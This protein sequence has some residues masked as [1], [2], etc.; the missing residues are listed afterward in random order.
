MPDHLRSAPDARVLLIGAGEIAPSYL[1]ALAHLGVTSI[2][3]LARTQASADRRVASH[4][5]RRGYGGGIET[6]RRIGADYT[7]LIIAT[8]VESLLDVLGCAAAHSRA[9]LMVEKPAALTSADLAN[10]LARHD[11]RRVT[12]ALNRLFF[13]SVS[14]LAAR[15]AV[16]TVTSAEFSFTEWIHRIDTTKYSEAA[17]AR[18]GLSNCIH[19]VGTVF[20]LIGHPAQLTAR[21]D[22]RNVVPWHPAGA[23][24]TGSGYSRRAVPFTFASDWRSAGR[25]SITVRT[26]D[27]SYHLAPMETLQFCRR[28][29]VGLESL[30]AADPGPL[31]CGFVPML[32]AWLEQD[33][34]LEGTTLLGLLET[35][36]ASETIFGYASSA[37]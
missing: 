18:W 13:P 6:L 22:G 32:R 1:D 28:G 9:H 24:F 35:I 30:V 25:W 14:T 15:L 12:V 33:A 11:A 21:Q 34:S 7:H 5:L 4:G 31:K 3:I 2:D 10:W 29:Q 20:H 19:V 16:E 23:V 17:L 36:R 26:T 27:G 37:D 8:P